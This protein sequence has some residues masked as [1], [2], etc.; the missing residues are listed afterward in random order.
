MNPLI[1]IAS[2]AS[3]AAGVVVATTFELLPERVDLIGFVLQSAGFFALLGT[4]WAVTE[5]RGRRPSKRERPMRPYAEY[6]AIF[7]AVGGLLGFLPLLLVQ[8]VS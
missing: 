6:G 8:E 7:G 3:A 2:V 4:A 1:A 5:Q